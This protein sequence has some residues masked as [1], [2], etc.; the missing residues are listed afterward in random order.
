MLGTTLLSLLTFLGQQDAVATGPV[1][2]DSWTRVELPTESPKA[3]AVLPL[4]GAL[5]VG[6]DEGLV[7]IT[8]EKTERFGVKQGLPHRV[9]NQLAWD[10]DRAE[11]WV[12]TMGG[13]ARFSAGRI[14]AFTQLD[15]GLANDV[16]YAVAARRGDV[17]AATASGTSRFD[18]D[19]NTWEIYDHTNARMH[20]PWCYSAKLTKDRIFLGVWGGG[21]L[22][23]NLDGGEWRVHK[24]PDGQMEIDLLR[25]DGLVSDVVSSLDVDGKHLWVATYFGLSRYDG[26][27][28][29]SWSRQDSGVPSDFINV[30]RAADGLVLLATDQG[31]GLYDGLTW[32][33]WM[34][35]E[36]GTGIWIRT[37]EDGQELARGPTTGTLPDNHV[38]DVRRL[39]DEVF[40]A[41]MGGVARGALRR[42]GGGKP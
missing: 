14:D 26:S 5:W 29:R 27:R 34:T 11:L 36:E 20:E 39:G 38:L 17:W 9:V 19:R 21:V 10:A 33:T 23:R 32:T 7:R 28:W 15:S 1:V 41:T 4:D 13:L 37:D 40:V 24:D 42:P 18:P 31:L 12:A 30:V 3:T 35:G 25:D 8:E 2:L 6:T 16:V 22:V